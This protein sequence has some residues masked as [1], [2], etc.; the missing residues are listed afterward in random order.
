MSTFTVPNT[1][2]SGSLVTAS[3]HNTNWTSV[4]SVIN[5]GLD[6]TNLSA[7]AG[8]VGSQLASGTVTATQLASEAVT[9]AKLLYPLIQVAEVSIS[10]AEMTNLFSSAK[11]LV[12][13]PGAGYALVF[14]GAAAILDYGG[15]AFATAA[16]VTVRYRTAT[17][18]VSTTLTGAG[19]FHGTADA[20]TTH[21][22][23]TTDY[24]IASNDSLA[25]YSSANFT[26]GTST[27][28]Y[29]VWYSKIATGL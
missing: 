25:L 19:F 3:D 24:V 22:A 21:K 6:T 5:G 17:T 1:F 16:N 8:I 10:S 4:A 23:I 11:V 2:S 26:L 12:D 14:M 7:S 9:S 27:V 29:K 15:T 20:M 28:R 18:T 13:A